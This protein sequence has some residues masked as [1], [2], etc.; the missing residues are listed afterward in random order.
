MKARNKNKNRNKFFVEKVKLRGKKGEKRKN[1]ELRRN[2]T[3]N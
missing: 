3:K 2:N 1:K